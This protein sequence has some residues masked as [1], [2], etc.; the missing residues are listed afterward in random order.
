MGMHWLR[1]TTLTWVERTFSYAVAREVAGRRG[2][3]DGTTTTY[4]KSHLQE[5]AAALSVLT[6]ESHPLA[7]AGVPLTP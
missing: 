4:V 3:G 2:K 6:G 1:H 7:S 5:V